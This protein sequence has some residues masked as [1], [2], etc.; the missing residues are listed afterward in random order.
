[1]TDP[2]TPSTSE[3]NGNWFNADSRFDKLYPLHIRQLG[4]RHWTSLMVA[5]MAANY[6]A[7]EK[8]AKILDIGSGIGKFCL[9]AAHYKPQATWFGIEQRKQLVDYAETAKATL[10]ITNAHFIHGNFTDLDFKQYD[11][12][13][14]Y[15]AFYEN[16]AGE[17]HIDDTVPYS[18]EIFNQYNWLLYKQ[19][20]KCPSGTRLATFHSVE[21]EIPDDYLHIGSELDGLVKFWMKE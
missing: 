1:M 14:F 4:T 19:L 6:L 12:F 2:T 18:A 7:V 16:I 10:G 11:H 3:T 17:S 8:G 9:A 20:Q 21:N 5:E 13:Y 15:N